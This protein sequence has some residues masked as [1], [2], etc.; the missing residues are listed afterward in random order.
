MRPSLRLLNLDVSSLQGSRAQYVCSICRQEARP[1]PLLA[2]QFLR[3]A[4]SNTTP[5]T[6]RVRRKIWGTDN[7]P[8][9]KD[10]YGGEGALERKFKKAQSEGQGEAA[11]EST[12][13]IEVHQEDIAG[14][15]TYEP[16]TTWEGI[17]RIGHL[18]KWSDLP[19]SEADTYNAFMVKKK[20]TKNGHLFL[21]AHQTAVELSL[22]HAL[23]MPLTS[24]C[25]VVEHDKAVFKLILKCKIQPVAANNS[26]DGALVY[27]NKETQDALVYVFKEI[28]SQSV[29]K[30]LEDSQ[31]DDQGM[32]TSEF[33]FSSQEATSQ[34][35]PFF[36]YTD[37]RD[38]GFLALPLND[39]A[40]KFA[41]LKRFSQL[42]GHSFPDPAIPSISTV[43]QVV[44][45]IQT[46]LNPKPK[47]LSDQLA[48]SQRLQKLPNVKVFTKRVKRSDRDEELGRKKV[49]EAE[50]RARGLLE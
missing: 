37:V 7:P 9:L 36:G 46:V 18:G 21:A 33:E 6:E 48:A 39:P 1:R 17:D 8:G 40:T 43:E 28:G 5:L 34:S 14:A 12:Q 13:P 4:S 35:V 49:I 3:N 25:N 15:D 10:P 32:Q 26:W 42:S 24:I 31:N 41:F 20:L 2:R 16:A 44:R 38:K 30:D 19:S 27:P 47:K 45:Y 50:L 29:A 11:E 22:M 23:K